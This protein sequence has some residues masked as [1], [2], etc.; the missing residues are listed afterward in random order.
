MIWSISNDIQ[1]FALYFTTG[2]YDTPQL[3]RRISLAIPQKVNCF[4]VMKASMHLYR[5]VQH[6]VP[7]YETV[8]LCLF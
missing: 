6:E 3:V 5:D 7:M 8:T 1:L 2:F 4:A